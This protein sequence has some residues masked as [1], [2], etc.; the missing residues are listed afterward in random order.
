[1]TTALTATTRTQVGH[2][3]KDLREQGLVPAV[4]YGHESKNQLIA[5]NHAEMQKVFQ[6]AGEST[7]IDLSIDGQ[8]PIETLIKDVQLEPLKNNL[9]H[10]DFY[11]IKKGEKIETEIELRFIAESPAVKAM[12]GILNKALDKIAVKCLPRDLI[13]QLDVDI[14]G[15]DDFV[16]SIHVKNL[17]IPETMELLTAPDIMVATVSAPRIEKEDTPAP[18][19]ATE[20]DQAETE[21]KEADQ[22]SDDS[23]AKSSAP[24][25]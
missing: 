13:Q 23:A 3:L 6:Q 16:K 17:V 11:Q 9:L 18:I 4:V 22:T 20:A 12:G 5:L 8:E 19:S 1:M 2:A 15:L 10:V 14:S 7:L 21:S 25:K 24:A